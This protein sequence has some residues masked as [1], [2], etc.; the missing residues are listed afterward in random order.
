VYPAAHVSHSTRRNGSPR[1]LLA[2][3][4]PP[5]LHAPAVGVC[6]PLP[7]P[8]DRALTAGDGGSSGGTSPAPPL[9]QGG[10]G[11]AID[12]IP[13]RRRRW[14]MRL[15]I[16][17]PQQTACWMKLSAEAARRR[18]AVARCRTTTTTHR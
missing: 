10:Q 14:R 1:P 8:P 17:T 4:P 3:P 15:K 9:F 18:V 11:W 2:P 12:V 7:G 13:S 6:P 16:E 5:A